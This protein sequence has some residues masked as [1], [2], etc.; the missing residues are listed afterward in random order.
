MNAANLQTILKYTGFF[1]T[2]LVA[3]INYITI[4]QNNV[5]Q[6]VQK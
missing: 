3:I 4:S 6:N 5:M 2:D 1:K